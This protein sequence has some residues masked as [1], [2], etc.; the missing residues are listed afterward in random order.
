M[1]RLNTEA[2]GLE[3]KTETV[4][5]ATPMRAWSQPAPLSRLLS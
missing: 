1:E 4:G 5:G 3:P 2:N